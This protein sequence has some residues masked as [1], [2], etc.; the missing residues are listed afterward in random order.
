MTAHDAHG[1]RLVLIVAPWRTATE[2]DALRT[3]AAEGRAVQ[4][5]LCPVF[6]PRLLASCLDDEEPADRRLA[7]TLSASLA[8][9][10]AHAGGR[11]VVVGSRRTEGMVADLAAWA[12]IEGANAPEVWA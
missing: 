4:E 8:R 10:V 1:A 5:G 2:H 9:T 7:L 3:D 6:A 12:E 11:C